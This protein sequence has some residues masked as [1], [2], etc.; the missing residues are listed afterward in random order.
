MNKQ[1]EDEF[2]RE[3]DEDDG[4]FPE[5]WKPHPGDKIV[6]I[7]KRYDQAESKFGL[8]WVCVIEA[9]N[10]MGERYLCG[11]WLSHT[12]LLDQFRKHQPK[13]GE[14]VGIKRVADAEGANG[15]YA[16]YVVK[17]DRTAAAAQPDWNRV[18]SKVKAAG[19][20]VPAGGDDGGDDDGGDHDVPF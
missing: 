15:R 8:R 3:L 18:G 11:V 4:S 13:I 6:G 1:H 19:Q 7:V 10:E 9:R 20:A 12:V 14:R 16:N 2:E 5:S 17:V